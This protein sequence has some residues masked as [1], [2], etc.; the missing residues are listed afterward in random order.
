MVII[1]ELYVILFYIFQVSCKCV[2]IF[3][4][5]KKIKRKKDFS[6]FPDNEE[7]QELG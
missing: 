2:I 6:A 4:W 3:S 7:M 5:L 1:V